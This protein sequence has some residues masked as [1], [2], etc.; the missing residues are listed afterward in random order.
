MV[1][2]QCQL[3]LSLAQPGVGGQA[4]VGLVELI[5][6]IKHP[7]KRLMSFWD[8]LYVLSQVTRSRFSA[9]VRSLCCSIRSFPLEVKMAFSPF[10]CVLPLLCYLKCL[11][12]KCKSS[13]P[14]EETTRGTS[15]A[16]V[17]YAKVSQDVLWHLTSLNTAWSDSLGLS[18]RISSRL[19]E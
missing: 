4:A 5:R 17:Q 11:V 16:V 15:A 3:S 13:Q 1:S 9:E 8:C 12:S 18:L 10:H 19:S 7:C 14:P 6:L 2:C